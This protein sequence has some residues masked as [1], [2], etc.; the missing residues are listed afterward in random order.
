MKKIPTA[1]VSAMM[2]LF[3]AG[4][5]A[6]AQEEE[7]DGLS[8]VPV[9]AFACNFNEGKGR[10][11][12]RAVTDE[13][14]A[15]MDAE[16]KTDY[17]AIT[18]WPNYRAE[19]TFDVGWLGAWSDGNAMGAGGDLWLSAGREIGAKFDEVVSCDSHTQFA[20]ARLK[21]PA[22]PEDDSDN[23]FVLSFSNCSFEDDVTMEQY[24]AAQ[25][26]WNAYADE[27]G[28]VGGRWM[29]F[30]VWGESADADYDFKSVGS[31]G[32]Y[33]ALGSNWAL[34]AEG[35]YKKSNE[36]FDDLLDCDSPRIYTARV[37][38]EMADDDE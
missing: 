38:R 15:W 27:I 26:E 6:I 35:H 4:G 14:N 11:D 31:T 17:F 3:V 22:E 34:Y 9:E 18:L 20:S 5:A 13:W 23:M 29:M 7:S 37:V 8:F 33:S 21:A 10:E 28:I 12:L 1:A 24:L 32:D 36:I 2:F 19:R 30:P 16:G 25:K